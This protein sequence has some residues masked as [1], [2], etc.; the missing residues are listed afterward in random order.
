MPSLVD[1]VK[2]T[3][4]G[5]ISSFYMHSWHDRSPADVP[6]RIHEALRPG[7]LLVI[8]GF[9]KPDVPFGFSVDE[10]ARD[11]GRLRILKSE[12]LHTEADWDKENRNHIVRFVAE[13]GK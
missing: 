12:S 2:D 1:T 7:G 3:I 11:Y 13:K 10:L 4:V 5:T 8:E 6:T 9:A